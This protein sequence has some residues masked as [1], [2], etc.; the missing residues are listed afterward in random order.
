M[1]VYFS[2]GFELSNGVCIWALNDC[3]Y[4]SRECKEFDKAH[5]TGN[6]LGARQWA[7]VRSE[8]CVRLGQSFANTVIKWFKE[9]ENKTS[10]RPSWIPR[11]LSRRRD[12]SI[13]VERHMFATLYFIFYHLLPFCIVRQ[14]E[15]NE[16]TTRKQTKTQLSRSVSQNITLFV[17]YLIEDIRGIV[18]LPVHFQPRDTI[19]TWFIHKCRY[20]IFRR[21][22]ISYRLRW[23]Y[24]L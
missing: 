12:S 11:I 18:E 22:V 23:I 4:L 19:Q 2:T 16:E 6:M 13:R 10:C 14:N 8:Q 1:R 7:L 24:W 17:Y 21:I 15:R 3:N 20:M 9:K 5:T